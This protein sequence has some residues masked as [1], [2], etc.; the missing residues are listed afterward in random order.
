MCSIQTQN[1][2]SDLLNYIVEIIGDSDSEK[3]TLIE[4]ILTWM[5]DMYLSDYEDKYQGVN[6]F[7]KFVQTHPGKT[8][9]WSHRGGYVNGP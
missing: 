7:D 9:I 5:D 3:F 6:L 2:A 8:L 4:E 1:T